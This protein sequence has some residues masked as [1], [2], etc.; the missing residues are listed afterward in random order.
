MG[1]RTTRRK[2]KEKAMSKS[3][4]RDWSELL[5]QTLYLIMELSET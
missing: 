5:D 1:K 2:V 4:P 3:M